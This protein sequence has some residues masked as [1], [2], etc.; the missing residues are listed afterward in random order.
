MKL[1]RKLAPKE[2]RLKRQI[3]LAHEL[4]GL[5][6]PLVADLYIVHADLCEQKLVHRKLRKWRERAG[7]H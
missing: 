5:S 1:G 6:N 3:A 4:A 7:V 2:Q